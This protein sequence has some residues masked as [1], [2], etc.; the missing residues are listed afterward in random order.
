MAFKIRIIVCN[1][2]FEKSM[3]YASVRAQ[4][5]YETNFLN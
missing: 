4:D 5:D 2:R 1:K 3:R